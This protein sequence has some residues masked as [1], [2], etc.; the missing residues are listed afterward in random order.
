MK[1]YIGI[2]SI[3][4]FSCSSITL[5]ANWW[6]SPQNMRL[7]AVFGSVVYLAYQ[8]SIANWAGLLVVFALTSNLFSFLTYRKIKKDVI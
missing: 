2:S 8:I 5:C 7:S 4:V 6:L 3:L 1:T